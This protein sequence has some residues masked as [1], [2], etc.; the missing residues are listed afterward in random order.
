MATVSK[1]RKPATRK[2]TAGVSDESNAFKALVL[3]REGNLYRDQQSVEYVTHILCRHLD[4]VRPALTDLVAQQMS[5]MSDDQKDVMLEFL[6]QCSDREQALRF[7][8]RLINRDRK[9]LSFL[10]AERAGQITKAELIRM[11]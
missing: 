6:P 7:S 4:S 3:L 11:I 5:A 2:T 8:F 1:P 10:A 9:L